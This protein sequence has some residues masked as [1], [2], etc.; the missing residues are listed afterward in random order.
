MEKNTAYKRLWMHSTPASGL[1]CVEDFSM[2]IKFDSR[3]GVAQRLVKLK[4][5]MLKKEPIVVYH[6]FDPYQL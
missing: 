2:F 5:E 4:T 1:W 6:N 3:Q